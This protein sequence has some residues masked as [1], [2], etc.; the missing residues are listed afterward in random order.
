MEFNIISPCLDEAKVS[1]VSSD[2]TNFA[3]AQRLHK[4]LNQLC[5]ANWVELYL[6]YKIVFAVAYF[7]I[8]TF[9]L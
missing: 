3:D 2:L 6:V 1:T 5:I 4:N 9:H 8:K 7:L